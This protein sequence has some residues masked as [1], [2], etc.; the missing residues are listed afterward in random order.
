MEIDLESKECFQQV[1]SCL[2]GLDIGLRSADS[3]MRLRTYKYES[4]Y[5]QEEEKRPLEEI[6]R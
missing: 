3:T 1:K 6:A 4:G 5:T 2:R